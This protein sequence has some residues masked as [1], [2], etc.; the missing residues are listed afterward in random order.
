[1]YR[2]IVSCRKAASLY[3][4]CM[5]PMLGSTRCC[6]KDY[7]RRKGFFTR[8]MQQQDKKLYCSTG[9]PKFL[10]ERIYVYCCWRIILIVYVYGSYK[11]SLMCCI[12]CPY[13]LLCI[14]KSLPYST[15][16]TPTSEIMPTPTFQGKVPAQANLPREYAH[17]EVMHLS[18]IN[19]QEN[20]QQFLV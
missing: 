20:V 19:C 16:I 8:S 5:Q 4:A 18:V 1:M 15:E 11:Q 6:R 13:R 2:N 17:Q 3:A 7:V 10:S 12:F 14:Q 9:C